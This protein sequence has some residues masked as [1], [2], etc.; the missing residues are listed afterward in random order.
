VAGSAG[1]LGLGLLYLART[2]YQ[3][4]KAVLQPDQPTLVGE[5][6]TVTLE[7]APRGL[8]RVGSQNWTAVSEDGN[9]ISVGESVRVTGVDGLVMTV[10]RNG[11]ETD[12][13]R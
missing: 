11:R 8:V 5:M 6:G 9:V 4:R 12:I 3:S 1:A 13:A 10:S 7:L 2:I